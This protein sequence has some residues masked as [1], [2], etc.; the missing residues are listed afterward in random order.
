M[1]PPLKKCR[2]SGE[3]TIANCNETFDCQKEERKLLA[4]FPTTARKHI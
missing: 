3:S 2:E 1:W 4:P